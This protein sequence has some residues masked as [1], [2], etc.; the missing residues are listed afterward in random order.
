MSIKV[1]K[2]TALASDIEKS[3]AL[4]LPSPVQHVNWPF[5][6]QTTKPKANNGNEAQTRSIV[7]KRDDLIH[8]II[9][10]NKWRKLSPIVLLAIKNNWRHLASFGGAY[11]NH[12]HALGYVCK[13][14]GIKC[15]AIIRGDY[16][17]HPS[18]TI[19]DLIAWGT[20][21]VYVTKREYQ[22]RQEPD[23]QQQMT[24]RL[25]ADMLIPEGGTTTKY[26][27]GVTSII[28]E[29]NAQSN[30]EQLVLPIGSGGTMAGLIQAQSTTKPLNIH[31]ISVLKGEGYHPKIIQH[32][33]S[34]RSPKNTWQIH[35]QFHHGGY[36]KTSE[37]L[38]QFSQHFSKHTS[39]ALDKVYNAKSFY[40]LN[41]LLIEQAFEEAEKIC[42][43]HTGGT[44]GNR[45][46]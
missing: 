8:P 18:P 10:G 45:K 11:S 23:Y 30:I 44:Q 15:T 40:A 32:L 6:I 9:S 4:Q 28:D 19:M 46:I 14:L 25:K 36:A 42:I 24:K 31:G 12:L 5:F 3:L 13:E 33:L 7:V 22:F 27:Q 1:L 21:I 20:D 43:L 37:P 35:E 41:Q 26:L 17:Q 29:L 2:K 34:S 38:L 39:I 16:S